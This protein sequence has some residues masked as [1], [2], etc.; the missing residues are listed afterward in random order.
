MKQYKGIHIYYSTQN[1]TPKWV[2][3][4]NIRPGILNFLEEK[5]RTGLELIDTEKRLSGQNTDSTGTKTNN[6]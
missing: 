3:N 1:S 6:Q 4:F 5:L 2:K